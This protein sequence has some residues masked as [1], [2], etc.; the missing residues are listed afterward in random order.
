MPFSVVLDTCVIYPAHLRDT[1]LRLAGRDLYRPLW[2]PA[3]IEELQRNLL[4]R[5][6]D[7]T[8]IG[9]TLE[10]MHAAFPHAA[11]TGYEHLIDEMTCDAKDR[12][13]L[14]TAVHANAAAI[15]TFNVSDF[16]PSSVNHLAIEVL[17]PDHFLLDL[18]DLAPR[19]VL[20]ELSAQA[21]ANRR[22]PNTLPA[23]LD[24]LRHAGVPGF[25]DEIHRLAPR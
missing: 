24:A 3:I 4:K 11:V 6:L 14:A 19:I 21:A 10:L 13:V 7:P 22:A 12:H 5:D 16:P 8:A 17:H 15:V 18:L 23:L 20:A 2:S 9:R 25:A 1:L